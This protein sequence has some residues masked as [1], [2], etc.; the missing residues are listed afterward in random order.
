MH[1]LPPTLPQFAPDVAYTRRHGT[2]TGRDGMS[3]R[4]LPPAACRHTRL[5][6]LAIHDP[7]RFD[8]ASSPQ[9][10][11]VL[12]DEAGLGTAAAAPLIAALRSSLAAPITLAP[13]QQQVAAQKAAAE[14]AVAAEADAAVAAERAARVAELEAAALRTYRRALTLQAC[15]WRVGG[16][17]GIVARDELGHKC[18][19]FL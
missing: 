14:A 9:V 13:A 11:K 12:A 2:T 15:E 7:P 5:S 10:L 6:H 8:A 17:C 16:G 1:P 3:P 19:R 18:L 4:V